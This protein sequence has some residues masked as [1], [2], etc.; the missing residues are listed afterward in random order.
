MHSGRKMKLPGMQFQMRG[1]SGSLM[2]TSEQTPT[3][4]GDIQGK[5]WQPEGAASA[6]ALRWDMMEWR[7]GTLQGPAQN[8]PTLNRSWQWY[9]TPVLLP[10]KSHGRRSLVGCSPWGRE[11]SD[12]TERL[13][14]TKQELLWYRLAFTLLPKQPAST[15]G[16][17][18]AKEA[19]YITTLT[20]S[21]LSKSQHP[22][23]TPLRGLL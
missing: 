13:H 20:S 15:R 3:W 4:S 8:K 23:R 14:F 22:I 19:Q 2:R 12:T 6:K 10:G 17:I 5:A 16:Y 18:K 11:E 21:N 1:S 7:E 9:P